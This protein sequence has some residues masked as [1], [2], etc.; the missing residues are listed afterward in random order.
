M[1]DWKTI[2]LAILGAWAVI[3]VALAIWA[4]LQLYPFYSAERRAR[5]PDPDPDPATA[6]A[7]MPLVEHPDGSL[8]VCIAADGTAEKKESRRDGSCLRIFARLRLFC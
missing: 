6:V 3:A 2:N 4:M 8:C 5:R 1:T 7:A